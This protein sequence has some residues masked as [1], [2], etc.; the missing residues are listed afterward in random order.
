MTAPARRREM[1]ESRGCR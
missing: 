1:M